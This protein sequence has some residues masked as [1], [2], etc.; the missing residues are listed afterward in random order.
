MAF[1]L[2]KTGTPETITGRILHS[3]GRR[4]VRVIQ[5]E[6][7][8]NAQLSGKEKMSLLPDPDCRGSGVY[9]K[10]ILSP[11]PANLIDLKKIVYL[12]SLAKR[13]C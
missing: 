10:F 4:G 1:L 12:L 11:E 3:E 8:A 13:Y 5:H 7:A 6:T 9:K 2:R